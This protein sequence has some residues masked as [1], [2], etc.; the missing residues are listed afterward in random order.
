V[1]LRGFVAELHHVVAAAGMQDAAIGDRDG[2]RYA[3][4]GI[5][6]QD[7]PEQDALSPLAFRARTH[8]PAPRNALRRLFLLYKY[9]DLLFKNR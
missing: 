7:V 2:F 5:Q 6:H 4:G 8:P 1:N 9:F 3:V